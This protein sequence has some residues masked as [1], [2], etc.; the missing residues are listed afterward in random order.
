MKLSALYKKLTLLLLPLLFL[1]VP[2]AYGQEAQ[3]GDDA[4]QVMEAF[5]QQAAEAQKS[6]EMSE[7]DQHEVL[8]FMGAALL[9]LILATAYFGIN[10]VVFDKPFFV[11]HMVCAG[12][13]VTLALA[14]AVA[15][16]VWFYPF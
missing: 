15:A 4:V 5:N 1:C 9:V 8:F 3:G 10:M 14:H 12:L 13:A 6:Y 11:Q 7:K 2:I 16:V